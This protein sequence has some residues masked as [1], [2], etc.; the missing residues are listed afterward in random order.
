V[1]YDWA[2]V[3]GG[4]PGLDTAWCDLC[5]FRVREEGLEG[6]LDG[7]VEVSDLGVLDF[8]GLDSRYDGDDPGEVCRRDGLPGCWD[9]LVKNPFCRVAVDRGVEVGGE[10][11]EDY[12]RAVVS[13]LICCGGDAFPVRDFASDRWGVFVVGFFLQGLGTGIWGSGGGWCLPRRL[14]TGRFWTSLSL[15]FSSSVGGCPAR[16]PEGWCCGEEGGSLRLLG[17]LGGT[18]PWFRQGLWW[19]SLG[20]G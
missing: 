3:C 4:V 11:V 14:R 20:W 15:S 9:R 18:G 12:F 10:V 5:E 17:W 7:V 13:E 2:G 19:T 8:V 1:D 16:Y 6:L